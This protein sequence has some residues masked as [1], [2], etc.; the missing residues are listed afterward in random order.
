[1]KKNSIPGSV[2]LLKNNLQSKR[3]QATD[4]FKKRHPEASDWLL[5]AGIA[6]GNIRS[7]LTKLAASGMIAGSLLA[8]SPSLTSADLS[9]SDS[10]LTLINAQQLR[11]RLMKSLEPQLPEKITGFVQ[12]LLSVP[13]GRVN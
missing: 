13:R 11:D 4:D 12:V 2:E 9:L 1:M 3:Q 6:V 5:S 8:F 7:S 10:A